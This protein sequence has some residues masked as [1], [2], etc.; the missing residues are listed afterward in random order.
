MI[1]SRKIFFILLTILVL[2]PVIGVKLWWLASAKNATATMAFA[3]K[4]ISGQLVRNYSVMMFSVTGTDTVFFNTGD[5]ELY[6]PGQVLPVLYQPGE[7]SDAR[8]NS[9]RSIWQDTIVIGGVLTVIILIIFFHP[10]IVPYRAK[11]RVT[12]SKPFIQ[13]I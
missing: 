10:E 5:Q 9:F 4:E 11:V 6:Q 3:G 8:V 1:F 2:S 13:I 12:F 7:P